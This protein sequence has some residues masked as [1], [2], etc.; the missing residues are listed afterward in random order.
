MS[1]Q[2][3]PECGALG[4][5][6]KFDAMMALEFES[7]TVFGAVHHITVLCYNLQHP[8][9]F[10]E[11]ALAWMHTS[12]RSVMIDGM[13]AATLRKYAAK[14]PKDVKIKRPESRSVD[15]KKITWSMTVADI[16]TENPAEYTE[17]AKK[18]AL[19]I[20]KDLKLN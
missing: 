1:D 11:E 5:R 13:S 15:A 8:S 14:I 19:S 4:C 12:L 3:C 6:E 2:A 16:R 20:L 9:N 18:W 7:P 10:S 17:D